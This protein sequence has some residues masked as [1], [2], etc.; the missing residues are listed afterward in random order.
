M[1]LTDCAGE[2]IAMQE[3]LLWNATS[4]TGALKAEDAGPLTAESVLLPGHCCLGVNG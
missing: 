1:Q 4:L 3:I 2:L